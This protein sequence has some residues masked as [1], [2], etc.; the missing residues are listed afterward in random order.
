MNAAASRVRQSWRRPSV[1]AL[2]ATALLGLSGCGGAGQATPS[3]PSAAS[4]TGPTLATSLVGADGA[5]WAVVEMG[6]SAATFDNFWELFVRPAG[7]SD[8]KLATPAGAASNGGLVMA[9]AGPGTLVTG[10]RPSQKLTF[11]PLAAS[12]DAGAQWSQDALVD[13]GLADVPGALAGSPAGGLLALTDTGAVESGTGLGASWTRLT[14]L[15]A[16]AGSPSGRACGLTALTAVAWSPS[17]SPMVAGDCRT[18]GVAG[19]FVLTAGS[20]RASSPALAAGLSRTGTDLLGLATAS[21][22]TTA[23]LATGAGAHRSVIA[24]WSADGSHWTLSPALTARVGAAG[25][26]PSVSFFAAGSSGLVLT[27][28]SRAGSASRAYTIGWRAARWQPL[29]SLPAGASGSPSA[30][31]STGQIA[32]L[33]AAAD[34]SLE[35]LVV[36]R[37]TLTV[38]Q[39]GSVVGPS[40]WSLA[41][42][43]RVP[44]PYGSS[45]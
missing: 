21:G 41:Q 42:I 28:G 45:G 2:A 33:A 40:G 36:S 43:L 18:P 1:L 3:G 15:A 16:L 6:G 24:A 25:A 44:V 9:Q 37:G 10:F 30:P 27:P 35:A 7:G 20:W 38:W 8:W 26:A 11:S 32:T 29:P 19:I 31:A 39:L 23:I 17:G 13:P 22:R 5:S 14:T 12:A 34:G 4:L